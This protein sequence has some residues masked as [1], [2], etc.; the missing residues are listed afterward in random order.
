VQLSFLQAKEQLFD[1]TIAKPLADTFFMKKVGSR[2]IPEHQ[3]YSE[4][5]RFETKIEMI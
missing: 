2:I 3:F 5:S 4:T 1:F